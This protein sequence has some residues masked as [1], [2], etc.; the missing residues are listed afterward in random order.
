MGETITAL[1]AAGAAIFGGVALVIK[2]RSQG[3]RPRHLLQRLWDWV[4][5]KGLSDDIPPTLR[6]QID[7]ALGGDDEDR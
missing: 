4:E 6:S 2:A 5:M 1:G 7:H 3:A